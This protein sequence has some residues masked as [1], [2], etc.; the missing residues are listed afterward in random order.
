MTHSP[1][2]QDWW[3]RGTVSDDSGGQDVAPAE[4]RAALRCKL[5]SGP[6]YRE[7][8][9]VELAVNNEAGGG[10]VEHSG[11]ILLV[12]RRETVVGTRTIGDG[13]FIA[14]HGRKGDGTAW[15]WC[16]CLPALSG[17]CPV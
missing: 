12:S 8:G 6:I 2:R 9:V 14:T 16:M 4:P 3:W 11:I 13:L 10:K 1:K 7:G 15:V 5:P 17:Q